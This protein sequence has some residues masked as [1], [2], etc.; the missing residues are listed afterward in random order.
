MRSSIWTL[1]AV[2]L[3]AITI[4]LGQETR[5][6][7]SGRITDPSGAGLADA[8]VQIVNTNT[9]TEF[10]ARTN[11]EGLFT[12][13][14]LLPGTYDVAVEKAGFKKLERNN[15]VLQVNDNLSLQLQMVL[16]DVTQNVVVTAEVPLL[17]IGRAHV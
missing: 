4:A 2:G 10:T 13:P 16:G 5:A 17:Q 9:K 1:I 3:I 7:I 11:N 12:V 14:Y 8:P 6:T 15:V